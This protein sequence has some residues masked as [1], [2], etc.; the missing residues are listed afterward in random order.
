VAIWST[1]SKTNAT[2]ALEK[3]ADDYGFADVL[4]KGHRSNLN[5][6]SSWKT[7]DW[8]VLGQ[9]RTTVLHP[10]TTAGPFCEIL[11]SSVRIKTNFLDVSGEQIRSDVRDNQKGVTVHLDFQMVDIKTCNPI[12]NAAIEIW[13]ANST[14]TYSGVAGGMGN[15]VADASANLK[16]TAMRGIQLT[17]KDGVV[18]FATLF[19]GHYAGRTN[20]IHGNT[21]SWLVAALTCAVMTHI[22]SEVL[23]NKTIRGGQIS[24]VSQLFFDQSLIDEVT[25]ISPYRENKNIRIMNKNDDIMATSTL[26]RVDNVAEYILVGSRLED[27]IFGWMNFGIDTTRNRTVNVASTCGANGCTSNP[28]MFGKGK[29][30]GGKGF[31]FEFGKGKDGFP[32]KGF[33]KGFGPGGPGMPKIPKGGIPGYE[34]LPKG[35]MKGMMMGKG[36]P[37]QGAAPPP[38]FS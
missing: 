28:K 36:M 5:L 9:N 17:D 19:P 27:G 10:E 3:R 35:F 13:G 11:S 32:G 2:D 23:P 34:P 12:P 26:G 38:T 1:D 29:G 6:A 33:P 25:A 22:D 20:H 18:N 21:I 31:P 14:G 7:A 16:S 30:K 4:A 8:T 24:F 15:I 37:G